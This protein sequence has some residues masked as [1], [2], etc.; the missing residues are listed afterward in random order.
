MSLF[1]FPYVVEHK[2]VASVVKLPPFFRISFVIC[3]RKVCNNMRLNK[4][5]SYPFKVVK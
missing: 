2:K 4:W 1:I 5:K 3:K